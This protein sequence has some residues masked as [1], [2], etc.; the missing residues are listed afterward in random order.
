[1][2]EVVQGWVITTNLA[3]TLGNTLCPSTSPRA[4]LRYIGKITLGIEAGNYS[5]DIGKIT[6]ANNKHAYR[7]ILT[8]E[9]PV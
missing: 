5:R 8:V 7:G 4:N 2:T 3:N 6:A 1:M 9:R